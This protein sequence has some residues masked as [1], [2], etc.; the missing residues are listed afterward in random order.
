MHCAF[1]VLVI[2]KGLDGQHKQSRA[3]FD[4]H[5][6]D[7]LLGGAMNA[8]IGPTL[9]P[10]GEVSLCLIRTFKAQT[11]QRRF[12]SMSNA[13]LDLTFPVRVPHTTG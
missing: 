2:A 1:A 7:L 12:L 6:R 4:E 3:F 5:R 11:F 13:C 8:R 10:A 9:F